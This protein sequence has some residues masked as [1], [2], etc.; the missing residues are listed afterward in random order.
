MHRSALFFA[1]A[2]IFVSIPVQFGVA[3]ELPE[4]I[5]DEIRTKVEELQESKG[6]PGIS[7]AVGVNDKL[8]YEFALGQADVEHSV[9]AKTTTRYRSASIAK[10]MTA[11][12]IFSLVEDGKLDLDA[13][14]QDYCPDYPTKKWPVTTRQVLGHLGG[15]RHYKS[16]AEARAT[17]HFFTLQ[18]AL[19]TFKDDPL[20][21]EPGTKYRYSSFG[22]NLL[23]SVAEGAA[24]QPFLFLL[25]ERVFK[26]AGMEFTVADDQYNIVPDRAKG[27]IRPSLADTIQ[28]GGLGILLPSKL[29]NAPL[30]D[31]SMKIP[32]GGLRST[33]GDLIRFAV[34]V[35]SDALLTPESKAT[36]WTGQKTTDGTETGY[37]LGWSVGEL[38]GE[39]RVSHSGGQSGTSTYLLMLPESG[40]CVAIMCNLQSVGL[41]GL[42]QE[43]ATLIPIPNNSQ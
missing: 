22:F 10:T 8:A 13:E 41:S 23:G 25:N 24:E 21:H 35:N 29:Y 38:N 16:A 15:V 30:H 3:D 1:L 28:L 11:V 12:A 36:I 2:I 43:I 33:A 4:K 20:I 32:G 17:G 6:I 27:Y 40:I 7:V 18:A 9:P 14:V 34:A 42:A 37:G 26:P 31:T 19:A 5:R 39:K